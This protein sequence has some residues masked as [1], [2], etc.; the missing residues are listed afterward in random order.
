MSD[1]FTKVYVCSVIAMM[2]ILYLNAKYL[3]D[4]ESRSWWG[5]SVYVANHIAQHFV[6]EN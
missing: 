4:F 3:A 6:A 2:E 5:A 1:I